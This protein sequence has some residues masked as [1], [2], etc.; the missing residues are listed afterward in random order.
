[1][2]QPPYIL[3]GGAT[4]L[5][6]IYMQSEAKTDDEAKQAWQEMGSGTFTAGLSVL[7][8][9]YAVKEAGI[10]SAENRY[11]ATLNCFKTLPENFGKTLSTLVTKFITGEPVQA[12][13]QAASESSASTGVLTKVKNFFGNLKEK[14]FPSKNTNASSS[15]QT[16]AVQANKTNQNDVIRVSEND[17]EII[18]P[19]A[20]KPVKHNNNRNSEIIDAEYT[21]L[22]PPPKQLPP[23]SSS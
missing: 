9:K 21:I 3:G 14:I 10:A 2:P 15:E 19:D 20:R 4:I 13:R 5:N 8:S 16:S 6:G 18:P 22:P 1:M 23:P 17:I 11:A 12:G 7:G